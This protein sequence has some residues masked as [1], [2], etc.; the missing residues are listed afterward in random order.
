MQLTV[1]VD[2]NTLIGSYYLGEP[3]VS[4]FIEDQDKKVL[5]DFGYS[6]AFQL[7]ARKLSI[8][9]L[10]LDF[11]VL[12]HGH[13][14]HSWGLIPLMKL[15][16]EAMAGEL[17]RKTPAFVA[18]PLA[19]AARRFK[20]WPEVGSLVSEEK[21]S[22]YFRMTLSRKP[23]RLTDRLWF[24]GEIPRKCQFE[25]PE[26]MGSV[27]VDGVEQDDFLADDSALA[28]RS[29]KGLVI[30]TGCS[31]AGICN[32][33]EYAKQVCGEDHVTDIVGGLH[34]LEPTDEQLKGTMAYMKALRP[35]AV[36]ACHCTDLNSKIVLSGVVNLKEV[37]VG[38]TLEY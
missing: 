17:R 37:G 7:N 1:L 9:L 24:L 14:D 21:L 38:L 36:H 20:K 6:D 10:D 34:L 26:G 13:L 12:S 23:V 28:Y 5:F 8:D 2:N 4:Y 3:A 25:S 18:H 35:D 22:R 31:H 29:S 33:V 32:V 15:H 30:I 16:S 27:L 11:V 19:L